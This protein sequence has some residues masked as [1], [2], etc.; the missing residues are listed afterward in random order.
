MNCYDNCKRQSSFSNA[1]LY[2]IEELQSQGVLESL[3]MHLSGVKI[4][5]DP[6]TAFI[7]N[8]V[9]LYAKVKGSTIPQPIEI[10][11]KDLY[12]SETVDCS[13][14]IGGKEYY[15]QIKII[16]SLKD[17]TYI[18]GESFKITQNNETKKVNYS[19]SSSDYLQVVA[20]DLEF[21]LA[22]IDA[23]CFEIQGKKFPFNKKL[24]HFPTL[25]W[26]HKGKI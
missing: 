5:T 1:K 3:S 25:T 16:K 21:M 14:T 13:V 11:P 4:N 17:T 20:K 7:S 23:G 8:D 15:S 22:Y 18:L 9:Y 24:L 6:Q 10:L 12:T 26:K 2:T 19:Y